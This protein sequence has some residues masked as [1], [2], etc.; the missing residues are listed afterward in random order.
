MPVPGIRYDTFA[1]HLPGTQPP[2]DGFVPLESAILA[3]A[4]STTIVNDGH[5]LYLNDEVL[6]KIVAIL[7]QP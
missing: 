4:E 1:G 5:Q 2:G 7:R 3:G 6:A